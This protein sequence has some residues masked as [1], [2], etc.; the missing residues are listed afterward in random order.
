MRLLDLAAR[1]YAVD[2]CEIRGRL[3]G[4]GRRAPAFMAV[5]HPP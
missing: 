5:C 3:S 2:L 1:D 4:W